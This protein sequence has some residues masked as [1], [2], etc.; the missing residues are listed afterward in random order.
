M[1]DI[2]TYLYLNINAYLF[3]LII[4]WF[5]KNKAVLFCEISFLKLIHIIHISWQI[6]KKI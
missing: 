2:N 5:V 1:Y 4:Y 6:N 3:V